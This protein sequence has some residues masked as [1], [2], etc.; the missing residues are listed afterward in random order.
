MLKWWR[1]NKAFYRWVVLRQN[2]Q[3]TLQLWNTSCNKPQKS[4]LNC[5]YQNLKENFGRNYQL[6]RRISSSTHKV[7]K[8]LWKHR[9]TWVSG[10]YLSARI[11]EWVAMPFS[12]GSSRPRDWTQVSCIAGGFFTLW[13]TREG[14]ADIYLAWYM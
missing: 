5:C 6:I 9:S 11:L 2:K 10:K 3:Q 12:K 14:H 4:L 8:H 13:A 1:R 7:E